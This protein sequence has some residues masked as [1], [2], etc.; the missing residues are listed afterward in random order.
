MATTLILN[1]DAQPLSMLPLSTISWQESICYLVNEKAV[2]LEWYE[3]WIVRSERWQTRVP[4]VMILKNYQKKKTMMRFSKHNVFLR[5]EYVCQYC[6]VETTKKTATLDHVLPISHGGANTWENC[7]CA[8][9][10][11]N[12]NKGNDKKIVPKN[13]PY[14]PNYFQLVEKRRKMEWDLRHPSWV[15]YLG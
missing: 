3:D 15:S 7:V 1:S 10:R 9:S 12:I 13:K 6:G 5:D 4:A 8:C 2:V 11:C 14:K